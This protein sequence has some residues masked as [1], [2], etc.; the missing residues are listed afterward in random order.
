M[1]KVKRHL[2][3][4][5][6]ITIICLVGIL[7]AF[8]I[9]LIFNKQYIR[10]E[11]KGDATTYVE[12][13]QSYEEQGAVSSVDNTVLF[14]F[15]TK[16]DY[17]E[18]GSVDDKK[19]GT[20]TITYDAC[21]EDMQAA[22]TRTVIV[23]DTTP[24]EIKL[25]TTEDSY[26]PYNHPYTEEG[27]TAT[28]L[29]DGDLT[30]QVKAEE[31]DG[32]VTYTVSDSHHN[33]AVAEREIHYD[34]RA[35]PVITLTNGDQV[36]CYNGEQYV[37]EY[38]AED[39]CDGDVTAK[40]KVEGTV[41]SNTNGDYTLKYTVSDSHNN[42]ATATRTVTVKD[43]PVNVVTPEDNKTIYLTYDDG[44]G[45][46]TAQ[47]LDILDK[48]NVKATFFTTSAKPNYA[49]MIAEEASRGHTVAVHTYTH[50]YAAIYASTSAYWDDFNQ[51]NAVVQQLT[52]S[53]S[54]MFRFP[55]GSSNTVSQN[56]CQGIMTTLT[57][58]AGAR[59]L[60]YF[61]WNVSSG[62]AGNINTPEEVYANV[63]SQVTANSNAGFPSVV[64][65]H[66]VKQFSVNAVESIIKWGLQN[67]YSFQ[68]LNPAS[69]PAHHRIAN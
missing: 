64:L 34:D 2:R 18:K 63:T 67:G 13:G 50:N 52:G 55:G 69:Y 38:T 54:T 39:D 56:Y 8:F 4:G 36:V 12:Y 11:P 58:Q 27:Y 51:Q 14:F 44:P 45:P 68:R 37:D 59:G 33:E 25:K 19:L 62:D 42:E 35:A 3:K 60:S 30:A 41:D 7:C 15:H 53:P 26:T 16:L 9:A 61:D 6:M 21:C 43:K 24:P 1:K 47:L 46:Y 29:Y 65:Q 20:Y 28:D 17:Q 66:D 22:C 32:K 10:L 57:R 49:N 23:Q 40:V 5:F 31:K 48:Y